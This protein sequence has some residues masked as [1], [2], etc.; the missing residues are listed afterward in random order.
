[1]VTLQEKAAKYAKKVE[2]SFLVRTRTNSVTCWTGSRT[3]VVSL[4]VEILKDFKKE[5]FH[6]K[7][8]QDGI[9]IYVENNLVIKENAYIF[10]LPKIPFMKPIFDAKGIDIKRC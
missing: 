8:E 1:M 5:E 7:Y 4:S 10:M 6:T 3:K 2:G 9:K